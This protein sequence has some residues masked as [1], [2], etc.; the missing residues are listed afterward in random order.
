MNSIFKNLWGRAR[1]NDTIHFGGQEP[2]TI[3]WLN[4][5]YCST[6]CSF[7]SGDVSFF[8]LS[9][10]VLLIF[11]KT[12]WNIYAYILIGL[13]SV[14]RIME[15]DHFLSDTI[16]SFII[17]FVIIRILHTIFQKLPEDL[18]LNNSKALSFTKYFWRS[19]KDSNPD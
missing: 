6:N 4:V 10:A 13:M 14:L 2:F 18:N 16:M 1:P 9:L 3:P 15:G 7:V 17:T 12:S 8:T 19:R 11:N 5:D